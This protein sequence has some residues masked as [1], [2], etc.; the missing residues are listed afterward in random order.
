MSH[1]DVVEVTPGMSP[2]GDL[3]D[4]AVTVEMMET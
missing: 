3:I 4:D 1:V 2:T